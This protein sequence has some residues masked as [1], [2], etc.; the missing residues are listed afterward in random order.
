MAQIDKMLD[1]I[2]QCNKVVAGLTRTEMIS[3][4]IIYPYNEVEAGG[5][6][7]YRLCSLSRPF[8]PG[9]TGAVG[10]VYLQPIGGRQ[11][12]PQVVRPFVFFF[13]L[14]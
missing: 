1:K 3:S 12:K 2:S 11:F 13:W 4:N 9:F 10:L 7:E 5:N 8:L 6:Q 14:L